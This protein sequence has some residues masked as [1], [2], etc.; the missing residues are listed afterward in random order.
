MRKAMIVLLVVFVVVIAGLAGMIAFGTS[1][2][3]P[4]LAAVNEPFKH[5]DFSDLPGVQ[6]YQAR[7]GAMLAYRSYDAGGDRMAVL[8]HGSSGSG[9]GM[10]IVAKAL[11]DAGITAY[12]LD[13]RGHGKSGPHGDIAYVGQLEDDVADF[14]GGLRADHPNA[15]VTLIGFSS[16]GGFALRVAGGQ[17]GALFDRYILVSPMLR[18]DAP[19]VRPSSGWAAPFIPR[20]IALSILDR[21]ALHGF[22]GLPVLA[23]AVPPDLRTVLTPTYSYRLWRNFAPHDDY[24]GD[25]ARCPKPMQ[26]LVGGAD[27][28]FHAD[29]FAPLFQSVRADVPV[30]VVPGPGHIAMTTTPAG[31]A[32]I[33]AAAK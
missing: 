4:P 6:T 18:Y 32:A 20:I 29:R 28:L 7:D 19:T 21:L 2:P 14:M 25:I 22:E 10:H 8:I 23:F 11:R 15:T 12:A 26:V 1:A 33:T 31:V 24:L 27:E 30:T 5:V 16:G 13:L 3:P 17:Y 9:S